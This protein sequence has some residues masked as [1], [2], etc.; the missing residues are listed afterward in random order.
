VKEIALQEK[1]MVKVLE[2]GIRERSQ[3]ASKVPVDSEVPVDND[4]FGI[5]PSPGRLRAK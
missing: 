4:A 1:A 5:K 2:A 3:E